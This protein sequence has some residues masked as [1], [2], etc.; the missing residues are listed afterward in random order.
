[1]IFQ[2]ACET[3]T[4]LNAVGYLNQ[5][6]LKNPTNMRPK[7]K[8]SI[9]SLTSSTPPILQ[10]DLITW[11]LT[12][13]SLLLRF[14]PQKT[15]RH[16]YSCCFDRQ[17]MGRFFEASGTPPK[18]RYNTFFKS[19]QTFHM[20]QIRYFQYW[21]DVFKCSHLSY[22]VIL[23]IAGPPKAARAALSLAAENPAQQSHQIHK[24]R[25]SSSKFNCQ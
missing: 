6:P 1:M 17:L 13:H 8:T 3:S 2:Q 23:K 16:S 25:N 19:K 7:E 18:K 10:R 5:P 21:C 9:N 15:W 20:K 12:S 24:I 4:H 22:P 14:P 11:C